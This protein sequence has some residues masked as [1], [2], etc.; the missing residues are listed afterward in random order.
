M[1]RIVVGLMV[2]CLLGSL[3]VMAGEKAVKKGAALEDIT[4]T[5]KLTKHPTGF[6][7]TEADGAVVK[8]MVP[9]VKGKEVPAVTLEALEKFIGKEVK[10]VGKGIT[11][12]TKAG[13]TTKTIKTV[14][15]V[16]EAAA[17][18][19][20]EALTAVTPAAEAPEVEAPETDAPEVEAPAEE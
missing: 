11:K 5:G 9:K 17:A 2:V 8:V 3:T 7:V 13:K 20:T 15:G 18:S 10:L 4:I 14:T 16:E 1:K 6:A 12:T 19:A